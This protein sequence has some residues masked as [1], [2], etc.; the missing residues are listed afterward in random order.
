MCV[1]V[2]FLRNIIPDS[3]E[4]A[5]PV[6]LCDCRRIL[7]MLARGEGDELTYSSIELKNEHLF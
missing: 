6:S 2:F 4:H 5:V 7:L 1:C 3:L